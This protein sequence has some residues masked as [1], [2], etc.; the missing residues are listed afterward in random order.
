[1]SKGINMKHKPMK[2]VIG[3][4]EYDTEKAELIASIKESIA[5]TPKLAHRGNIDVVK[6]H[7]EALARH[8]DEGP[9]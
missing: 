9:G 6:K 7:F 3:V 8:F 1:M 5:H 4:F 2:R